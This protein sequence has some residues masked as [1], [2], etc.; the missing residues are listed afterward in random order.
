MKLKNENLR[1]VSFP[2]GGIGAGCIGIAGN[3]RLIDW[4]I[5]NKPGKG[6]LNG[7]SH[8]AVKAERNGE[9]KA[10]RILNG[11]LTSEFSGA[12]EGNDVL[13][14]GFGWGPSE[15]TLAGLPHFRNCEFNGTFPVAKLTFS[16]PGFPAGITMTA[17]S[18]FVPGESDTASMPAAM[19]EITFEN[20][21]LE[22]FDYSCA[23]VLANPWN[24]DLCTN[25]VITNNGITQ[26]LLHNNASA[27]SLEYGEIALSTDAKNVSFQEYWYR[28]SWFDFLE[29][30]WNDLTTPGR[31]K[32]RNYSTRTEK[33][34][35]AVSAGESDTGVLAVHVSLKPHERRTVRF[36]ISWY[37]PNRSNTW[38]T[39]IEEKLAENGLSENKWKN[40][41]A[42]LCSSAADAAM[43]LFSQY[44]ILRKQVFLFCKTLHE[45]TIPDAPLEGAAEN[46]A[47]LISPTCLRLED[48]T[49]WG[50][51]GIGVQKGSCE[52]TC[53]HV[54]N[55]AQALPLLF[56]DLERTIRESQIKYGIDKFGGWHF[57]L[58]LP[59]GIQAQPDWKRPCVDGTYGEVMKLYREWKISGD[60]A[61]LQS[62]WPQV[63]PAIEYAWSPNNPDRWDVERKGVIDGRQHHTLDMEQFGASGWLNGHYLGA[64]KAAAEMA[65]VCGD[66]EFGKFCAELFEKGRKWSEENLFNGEYYNQN[67]DIH[68]SSVLRPYLQAGETLENNPYWDAEHRQIKYQI[69]DGCGIDSHLGQWYATLYGI[70]DVFDSERIHTT[71]NSIYKYNFLPSIRDFA[72]TW[73]IFALNDEGGCMICVWPEGHEKPVI[74][75]P[76]NSEAMTGFEW[77]AAAHLIMKGEL[78]KGEALAKAIRDRYDGRKR[79]PWNEIECGSNYARSMASFAML[80]AYSGFKYD[81]V[82]GM[83]GF[84]PVSEGDFR[85][86]WSLGRV[87]GEYERRDAKQIIRVLHG[88][89]EFKTFGIFAQKVLLNGVELAGK[90]TNGE[91]NANT[92]ISVK[93][94][95]EI[96]LI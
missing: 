72:N 63:K 55:Y 48:G 49:F 6:C 39:D 25:K 53:Q 3:G 65:P 64:L 22:A 76:Y 84:A 82:R 87:W 61:W 32:N 50:W 86:F 71:L 43:R 35:V 66:P 8:F 46:L 89:A 28:G 62:L 51:E 29:V 1:E 9:V 41:Y 56:P 44:D 15:G 31:F 54:W 38:R 74:P 59:L 13:F 37:I 81:M 16:D 33:L 90:M 70:G 40:Y 83:I 14:H 34:A 96:R 21:S 27:D 20:T 85:C 45:S 2:V 95:D 60:T 23:A 17:W 12:F 24:T 52:G 7:C 11:D 93:A 92:I 91:W 78:A 94:M 79:N 75:L 4:E 73:R 42:T 5:F 47:V 80:Q 10:A 68:D 30:Y 19:F 26:L 36:M 67:I 69:A 88:T 58:A 18:P 57:R 77:A